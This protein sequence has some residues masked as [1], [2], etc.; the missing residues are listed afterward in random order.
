MLDLPTLGLQPVSQVARRPVLDDAGEVIPYAL[1][2]EFTDP[3]GANGTIF[4]GG[5][6]LALGALAGWAIADGVECGHGRTAFGSYELCSPREEA[7]RRAWQN[8]GMVSGAFFGA[9]IGHEGDQTT[10]LE[11]IGEIRERSISAPGGGTP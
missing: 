10:W 11:A 2:V 9:W 1:I 5:L 6:G 7:L 8:I 3:S 4:G